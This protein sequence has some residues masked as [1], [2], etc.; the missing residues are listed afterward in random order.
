MSGRKNWEI[1]IGLL[2]TDGCVS[3]DRF[4]IFHNKSEVLHN[5]FK[6]KMSELFGN[7][8][9]TQRIEKNG[10]KRTQISRKNIVKKLLQKCELKTFRRKRL[11]NGD[12]PSVK[13]PS[14]IKKLP[15]S[16]IKK[17]LQVVFSADGSISLSVRWH[18]RNK[19]WE[20]RRRIELT[21]KHPHLRK[22][23]FELLKSIGFSPRTS[24][25]NITLEKKKDILKFARE[26]R[27]ID[28]VKIGKDSKNW[29]GYVK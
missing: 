28:G 6:E 24:S 18:K 29:C 27:F 25:D 2:L 4:I 23:Y 12:F 8:H 1:V 16:R 15:I 5:L 13:I 22:E 21:C 3:S 17:F 7:L 11:K 20:I 19:S 10:T 26:I 9:F 14:F